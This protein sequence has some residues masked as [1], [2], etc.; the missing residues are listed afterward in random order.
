M[1]K[2]ARVPFVMNVLRAVDDVLALHLAR[3]GA[4]AGHVRA[5][6]GLGHAE[7]CDALA[8]QGGH[9]ELVLLLAGA[10][11][12]DARRRHVALDEQAHRHTRGATA[13]QGLALGDGEPVVAAAAA[14]VLGVVGPE[15]AELTRLLEDPVGEELVALPFVDVGGELL[16]GKGLDLLAK[17]LVFFGEGV[18]HGRRPGRAA[19]QH[20]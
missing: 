19:A 13:G 16:L 15:D 3:S 1:T 5:G 14:H 11:V 18:G 6:A 2:L 4:D 17:E 8:A 7:G 9:E 10:E 12:V 20:G